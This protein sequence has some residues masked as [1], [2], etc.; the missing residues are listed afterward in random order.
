[1]RPHYS[2]TTAPN[3]EP[4][5]LAQVTAHVRVDSADD[6]EY[7]TDLIPVGREYVDSITGRVSVQSTWMVTAATWADLFELSCD[8]AKLYRTPLVSVASVKFYAPDAATLTT[9]PTT[10]YRVI[11]GYEPGMIQ[12]IGDL[13]SVHERMDAIQIT[14]VAGYGYDET[15]AILK[16][17]VKMVVANLY[18]NRVP[19]ITGMTATELP[20][21]LNNLIQNQR[22]G[23]W[24]A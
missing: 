24:F 13:P 16:H 2:L 22:V 5:T 15:P 6:Q 4:V 12:F 3:T 11:T 10:D 7:I 18:E 1:M 9:M 23:G 19:V 8:T 14:F 17:A 20:Q 21:S